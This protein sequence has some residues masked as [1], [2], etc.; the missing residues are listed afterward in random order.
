[1]LLAH[2]LVAA[3]SLTCL[4]TRASLASL[5]LGAFEKPRGGSAWCVCVVCACACVASERR[6]TLPP[7][8]G[9]SCRIE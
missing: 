9:C 6:G 8:G 4:R 3:A 5:A 1:M 7:L 2:S